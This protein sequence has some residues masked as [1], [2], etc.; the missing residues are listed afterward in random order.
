MTVK[1]S[2]YPCP[3]CKEMMCV[4]GTD[5]KYKIT[6]CG[7]RFSFKKT[8]CQKDLDRKYIKTEYG[9]ELAK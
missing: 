3:I 9:L 2:M 5:N 7:H 1:V 8:K 6:S 4:I